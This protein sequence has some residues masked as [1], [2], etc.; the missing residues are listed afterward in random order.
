MIIAKPNKRFHTVVSQLPL[1]VSYHLFA[2]QF[3]S[4]RKASSNDDPL[5][6]FWNPRG[7]QIGSDKRFRLGWVRGVGRGVVAE[8]PSCSGLTSAL[9][10]GLPRTTSLPPPPLSQSSAERLQPGGPTTSPAT[11]DLPGTNL[12]PPPPFSAVLSFCNAVVVEPAKLVRLGIRIGLS[13]F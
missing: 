7:L 4:D 10:S 5:F 8:R 1:L 2:I 12:T 9:T 11:L 6:A 3:P 13:K